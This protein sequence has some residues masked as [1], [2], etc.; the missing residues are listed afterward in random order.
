M[1]AC[2]VAVL[3][4]DAGDQETASQPATSPATAPASAPARQVDPRAEQVLRDAAA[5]L[6]AAEGVEFAAHSV[7]EQKRLGA[8]FVMRIDADFAFAR[9]NRLCLLSKGLKLEANGEA[10]P[11]APGLG[12]S[13]LCDGENLHIYV[14]ERD[15]YLKKPAPA[16]VHDLQTSGALPRGLM[17]GGALFGLNLIASHPADVIL[18]NVRELTYAGSEA[19]DDTPCHV[20]HYENERNTV[21]LW[22]ESGERPVFRK[23]LITPQAP[24]GV[25]MELTET[26]DGW[27][28][29]RP[30]A[31]DAFDLE[32]F[33]KR[34]AAEAAAA[35]E[36]APKH[37]LVGKPAAGEPL[38]LLGGGTF[39]LAEHKGKHVVI[40]DFWATWCP[41]CR[42]SM[43]V[44][45]KVAAEYKD[46]GVVFYGVNSAENQ[47]VVAKFMEQNKYDF[48]VPLDAERKLSLHY[49]VT[50]IPMTII[51]DRQGIIRN[52][53]V[54]A[55]D[56]LEKR[57][58]QELDR[59][60]SGS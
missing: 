26:Y 53:H 56:D 54:G 8:S 38:T 25:T 45:A 33:Q 6:A 40:L 2:V 48:A 57:L 15:E 34:V 41:P 4:G 42:K 30:T 23:V 9:P 1:I 35:E 16:D 22:I 29:G 32:S 3:P 19:L 21:K 58:R 51:I 20:L 43:P 17:L 46:K 52:V 59:L 36:R 28:A 31:T 24:P 60:S 47:D 37:P 39:N 5:W 18:Q 12:G 11:G 49:Q 50:G 7:V 10:M 13:V 14:P 27:K 44:L 55:P